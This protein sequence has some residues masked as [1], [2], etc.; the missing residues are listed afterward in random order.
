M[1]EAYLG[2]FAEPDTGFLNLYSRRSDH[3][4]RQKPKQVMVRNKYYHQSWAP[5]GVDKNVLEKRLGNELEP[6]GL[7]VLDKLVKTPNDLTDQ[8][9]ADLLTYLEFQRIRV[10]RQAD[11][12]KELAK[13]ALTM[14]MM[15]T[16]EGRAALAIGKIV[17]EDSFRFDFM[18][19]VIGSMSPYMSRMEW[20][21][22]K[23][24][25][26]SSFITSDS[27]VSFVN[28]DFPPP[29][30]AG[31]GLYGTV[32]IF[33]VDAEHM[34]VLRHPEYMRNEKGASERLPK[35]LDHED[36]VIALTTSTVWDKK[37]VESHNWFMYQLAQ[38]V[39][40]GRDKG[41]LEAA[42]GKP[43]VGH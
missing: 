33:P 7:N 9:L 42:I 32:A 31:I 3:W 41:V 24:P 25:D 16:R 13:T 29:V 28:V 39:I 36:G 19:N 5:D 18:R 17:I 20:E 23:A 40:V 10:P 12:A 21:L 30:E 27:P 14:E 2:R 11:L 34:L 43:L 6:R 4:R 22:V 37:M 26:G 35:G 8:D 38:D 1:P 15:K